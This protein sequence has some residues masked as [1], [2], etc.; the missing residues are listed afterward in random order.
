M[1]GPGQRLGLPAPPCLCLTPHTT[2]T[3]GDPTGSSMVR[4]ASSATHLPYSGPGKTSRTSQFGDN[5]H[6]SHQLLHRLPALQVHREVTGGQERREV[7]G[8]GGR[9]AAGSGSRSG[10]GGGRGSGEAAGPRPDPAVLWVGGPSLRPAPG[11]PPPSAARYCRG[12]P[13]PEVT[14][15]GGGPSH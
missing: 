1:G 10:S 12:P 8:S 9:A 3:T 4:W 13:L 14:S 2:T 6:M 15:H 11:P 7:V 5:H